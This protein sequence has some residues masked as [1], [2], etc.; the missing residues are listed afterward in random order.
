MLFLKSIVFDMSCYFLFCCPWLQN[1]SINY[2]FTR[3]RRT[4][5]LVLIGNLPEASSNAPFAISS[6]TPSTS[7][8]IR[9]GFTTAAQY[10]RLPLPLPIRTSAGLL[11]IGLSGKMRIHTLPSPFMWPFCIFRC[12]VLFGCNII[13]FVILSVVPGISNYYNCYF[14]YFKLLILNQLF[15]PYRRSL[16]PPW[17]PPP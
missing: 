2:A 6:L 16:P 1:H 11:V 14:I 13:Q 5:K 8:K 3:S 12:F 9:P 4:T 17:P 10:S 7:N 15:I